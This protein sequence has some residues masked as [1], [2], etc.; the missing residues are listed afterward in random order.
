[1]FVRARS[2]LRAYTR[3]R[4]K[5]AFEAITETAISSM[6]NGLDYGQPQVDPAP[7]LAVETWLQDEGII[8]VVPPKS[9]TWFP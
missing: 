3:R 5:D 4:R 6:A 9:V 1:M 7:G 2:C 8:A